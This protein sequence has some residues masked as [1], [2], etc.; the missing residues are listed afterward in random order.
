[1]TTQT[2][3]HGGRGHKK[4]RG[5]KVQKGCRR[6]REEAEEE[7]ETE[8]DLKVRRRKNRMEGR[9]ERDKS[10]GSARSMH[11]IVKAISV[12]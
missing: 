8:E 10:Q 2:L 11:T 12:S 6:G 1:M 4:E 5:T 7:R 3:K 9:V